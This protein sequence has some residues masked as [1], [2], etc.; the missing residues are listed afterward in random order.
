MN[1][2]FCYL[3]RVRYAECDAQ[4]VVFNGRYVDYIDVAVTEFLRV[5]WGNYN[6]ILS[7][8]IDNQVVHISM[9]WK[10]PAHFD[11]VIAITVKPGKIGTSSYSL[12]CDFYHHATARVLASA[13]VIY[14]MVSATQHEKMAIPQ[15]MRD[16]LE[17]GA[18]GIRIDHAGSTPA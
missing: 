18:P 13:E 14:V 9:D 17:Q 12:K 3:L 5:I 7:M 10:A 11:E 15:D 4:K 2:D 1:D 6:D 16:R 8:G